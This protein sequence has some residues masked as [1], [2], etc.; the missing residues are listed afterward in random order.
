MK[1]NDVCIKQNNRLSDN[2]SII[3]IEL[4]KAENSTNLVELYSKLNDIS[5]LID[6][7]IIYCRHIL[8][9]KEQ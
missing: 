2:L 1:L 7:N 3:L 4:E 8:E 9:G 6:K 5:L